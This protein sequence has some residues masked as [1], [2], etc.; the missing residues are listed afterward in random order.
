MN[1]TTNM[2]CAQHV[3]SAAGGTSHGSFILKHQVL[4]LPHATEKGTEAQGC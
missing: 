4:L 2:L 1:N 3:C